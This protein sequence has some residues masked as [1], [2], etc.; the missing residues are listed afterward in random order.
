VGHNPGTYDDLFALHARTQCFIEVP[1]LDPTRTKILSVHAARKVAIPTHELLAAT[2]RF[3]EREIFETVERIVVHERPHRPILG[4]DFAGEL[5][6]A[7]QLHPSG[8]DVDR[9]VY[10][11]HVDDSFTETVSEPV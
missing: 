10:L 4:D 5:H 8:L 3:L 7:A 11:F 6:D 1:E 2:N 9:T